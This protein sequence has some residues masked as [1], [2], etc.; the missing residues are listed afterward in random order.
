MGCGVGPRQRVDRG[1]GKK[2][3]I[4]AYTMSVTV[5]EPRDAVFMKYE[6]SLQRAG[7]S[8]KRG[9]DSYF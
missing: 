7:K 9:P 8:K 3:F 1:A 2:Q 6:S 5:E 4:T